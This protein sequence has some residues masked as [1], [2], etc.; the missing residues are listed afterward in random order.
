[1][2]VNKVIATE[3]RSARDTV[4][5]VLIENDAGE[6]SARIGVLKY[7]EIEGCYIRGAYSDEEDAQ[8]IAD[9]GAKLSFTEA[10]AFFP[11][12]TEE[13]YKKY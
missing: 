11:W 6:Q 8:Y 9:N 3:W 1:M 10:K 2:S 5:I 12:I 4:G 7:V 13:K